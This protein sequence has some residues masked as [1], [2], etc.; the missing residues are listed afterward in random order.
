M[1]CLLSTIYSCSFDGVGCS[2]L[3]RMGARYP[4]VLLILLLLN[5]ANAALDP[6]VPEWLTLDGGPPLVVARGGFSGLFPES[7]KFA[8]RF[9]VEASLPDVVLY[10]DLQFSKNGVGFCRRELRLENST[11]ISREYPDRASTYNVNGED[12]YGW[13]SVDFGSNELYSINVIQD[14]YARS[15]IFDGIL[16][17]W[18]LGDLVDQIQ[19]PHIWVNVEYD[20]FYL[21]HGLST[22]DY[23]LG[24]PEEYSV[25]Y[26]SSPE[27]ALLKSLSGKLRSKTKLILRFLREDVVEPSTR[28]T[29]GELLKDLK[30]IKAYASGILVHKHQIWPQNKDKYL[31]PSTSLV[32]DAHAIG[33]E[34]HAYGFAND[35]PNLSHNYSFDP[36][37]EY[38]QFI[39]NS[40]FSVDGLLTD[41][42]PTASEAVA[43]FA[44]TKNNSYALPPPG[45]AKKTRPLIITHNGAS[46]IFSD[47]T[48]LA[49]QQAVK[50]GAD[51]IDCWVRM[52]KDGVPFCLG[53][54]D[55]NCSTTAGNAFA[56]KSNIVNEIQ[57]KSGIFSFDLSWSEIQTLKPNL[58]GPFSEERLE[59]NPAAKN[60]GKLLTLDEFLDYAKSSNVSGILIGIEHAPYLAT[61]GLD[62]V[63]AISDALANSGYDKET[64]QHVLIQ[65]EETPVLAA[66]KKFPK[67]KRVLT[68]EF[69]IGDVSK[70]SVVEIKEIA[71]AVKLRRSSATRIN[72]Y[73]LS[74]F[75]DALVKRL[76]DAKMEVYVG[77]LKNEFMNLAFDYW[78]DPMIEI[79]TDTWSVVA[80]GLVTEFPGTAAAYFKSP[81]SDVERN[82]SFIIHPASAGELVK[83]AAVG[84]VPPAP[85]PA[86]MLQPADILDP[87]LPLCTSQPQFRTSRC[88]LAPVAK[89]KA[90]YTANLAAEG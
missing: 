82:L 67:F 87:P 71:N 26:V 43:C 52:S 53:S 9:A 76:H 22:E 34:V 6:R 18:S 61:I 63:G 25:T 32:K 31:E 47:S 21:E 29:Y 46:G 23:I 55:L 74:G 84:L 68:I 54:T 90:D 38:L 42:S 60:A 50:D 85:P 11:L 88:R 86:P 78:A 10:C 62:V 2:F 72:G 40:D 80:D 70:P 12:L 5:G 3:I 83:L 51:I 39:D 36:S 45:N 65:S 13:F 8:Y 81:C 16:R 7:T 69:D 48:D 64:K 20:L 66:F 41:F 17:M 27:V 49:Y 19:H 79:A 58:I 24:L 14:D 15:N 30:S 44:H 77:V 59:R 35:D 28:K 89:A 33:L 73:F 75:T 57:N 56:A 37:A 4:L 1:P